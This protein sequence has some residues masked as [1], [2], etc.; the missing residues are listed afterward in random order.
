MKEHINQELIKNFKIRGIE[1]SV[2]DTLEEAKEKILELISAEDKVGIGNSSTLKSMDISRKLIDRGNIVY[3]KT[4]ANNKEESI[5]IK[6]KSLLTDWYISGTN[7]IT[8]EGH[9][10]NIDHSGNR[11]AAM[12]YGPDNVIVVVGRNKI[13]ETLDIAKQRV[14]NTSA[15]LNAKR[16]GFNPP[17][18]ELE[19][20]IDCKSDQRVCFNFV[21]IEGQ[22]E[23]DRMKLFIIDE[24]LGF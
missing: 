17:C 2:F 12:I 11:V 7:A 8:K 16:A 24:D 5:K 10:V 9:I 14:R 3:D 1:A 6:K 22:Y 18:L 19:K 21:I 13:C 15:I 20:C 23:K 4:L